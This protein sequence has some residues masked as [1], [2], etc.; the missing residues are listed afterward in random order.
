MRANKWI[1][2]GNINHK[3]TDLETEEILGWVEKYLEKRKL[4]VKKQKQKQKNFIE[5]G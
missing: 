1:E 5:Q 3:E 4:N 2:G